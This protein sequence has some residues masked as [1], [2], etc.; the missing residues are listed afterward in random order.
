MSASAAKSPPNTITVA[1]TQMACGEDGGQNLDNAETL[2][3]DAAERGANIVLLQELFETPYFCKTQEPRHF[4]RARPFT[5]NPT[6]ARFAA[7]A[8]EL[9]VVLPI[10]FFEKSGPAYFNSLAMIDADGGILGLY[11]KSHIPQGPG[12]QEKYYFS[13]GDTGFRVFA[14][15]FGAVG[16]AICW[17]QW[18][19]EAARAMVLGGAEVLLY[20]TAIGSEPQAPEIDSQAHWRRA[21]QGHA[22]ANMV[23]VIASNRIGAETAGD[24][25]LTFYGSSFIADG[26]GAIVAEA[27]R[28]ERAVITATFE[29][30]RLQR[31]RASW[32]LLRDRRADLYGP[33][34]GMGEE[35]PG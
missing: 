21:M 15:R 33:L 20:P 16:C 7:L 2:V 30:D 8:Q 25:T 29:R 17:D 28:T 27:G 9:G 32:G 13:P 18:F 3:R 24:T 1:A 34:M 22:A 11:R 23:P 35:A 4:A 10:S 26:T 19:P 31:E 14:T 12:Y 5:D 6:L